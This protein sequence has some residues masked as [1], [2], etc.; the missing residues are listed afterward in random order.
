MDS[1]GRNHTEGF[2]ASIYNGHALTWE[3]SSAGGKEANLSTPSGVL[4]E[5]CHDQVEPCHA[6]R[7]KC[8]GAD[9][10]VWPVSMLRSLSAEGCM[11]YHPKGPET[12]LLRS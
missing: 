11:L 2:T 8:S 10:L 5:D 9:M 4:Q 1:F 6:E 12:L 7:V 3:D